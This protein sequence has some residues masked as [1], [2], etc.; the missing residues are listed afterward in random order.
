MHTELPAELREAIRQN[1]NEVRL[2]DEQT[3][4]VYVLVDEETHRRAMRALQE[5]EDWQAIE[6]GLNERE[7]G[8]G[9]TRAEVDAEI[10]DEFGFPPRA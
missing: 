7:Q 6:Q 2:K 10:R 9:Q 5:Q 4:A 3:H 8:L 1:P